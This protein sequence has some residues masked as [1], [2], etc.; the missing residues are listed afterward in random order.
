MKPFFILRLFIAVILIILYNSCAGKTSPKLPVIE[1]R[2]IEFLTNE[3]SIFFFPGSINETYYEIPLIATGINTQQFQL[4]RDFSYPHLFFVKLKSERNNIPQRG[5]Y[6]FLDEQTTKIK[7]DSIGECS[8]I[9]GPTHQ[10]YVSKFIPFIFE[11]Y[12]CSNVDLGK[13]EFN[14]GPRFNHQLSDYIKANPDSYVALWFL[15][16][17]I[18]KDGYQ[19]IFEK[20]L[21]SFSQEMKGKSLWKRANSEIKNFKIKEGGEFPNWNLKNQDLQNEKLE[22]PSAQFILI[23]FWFS[24]CLPC[25]KEFPALK[26]IYSKY[27]SQGFE[28]VSISVDRTHSIGKWK[29]AIDKHQLPWPNFLD[30]NGLESSK[31]KITSFPTTFLLDKNGTVIKKNISTEDLAKFLETELNK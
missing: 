4:K 25:L 18:D 13:L 15:I 23:D 5:G 24:S 9:E 8:F 2:V 20:S 17:R 26:K 27:N 7:I 1:G 10:E 19:T 14:F 21:S 28:L 12:S 30:E 11:N 29:E 31:E 16:N 22:L 3:D 6:Y